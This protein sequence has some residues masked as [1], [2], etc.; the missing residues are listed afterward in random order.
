MATTKKTTKP[1]KE[2]KIKL[3][4]LIWDVAYNP[5]LIAQ[6]IYVLRSNQRAG[7]ANAKTRAQ[8]RGGG[9][10]P[11]KQKGTGRA[12]AGSNRSPLWRGGGVTFVPTNRNWSKRINKKMKDKAMKMELSERMRKE[13]LDFVKFIVTKDLKKLRELASKTTDL[14]K[15]TLFV[16]QNKELIKAVQNMPKVKVMDPMLMN[17]LDLV[18]SRKTFVDQDSINVIEERFSNAR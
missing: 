2:E 5:D 10:K 16:S 18:E 12:R 4:P 7:T 8:V 17:I 14:S 1:K 15:A 6:V 3:N 13:N 11:W 9:R